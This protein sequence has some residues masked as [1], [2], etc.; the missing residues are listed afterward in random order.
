MFPLYVLDH[1][2]ILLS[3]PSVLAAFFIDLRAIYSTLGRVAGTFC[4]FTLLLGAALCS[5]PYLYLR[6]PS[7]IIITFPTD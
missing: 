2:Q 5:Q 1:I 7:L 6:A 3:R 4:A